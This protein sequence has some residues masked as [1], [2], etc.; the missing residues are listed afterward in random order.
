[1][2]DA[3]LQILVISLQVRTLLYDYLTD[4]EQGSVSGRNPISSINEI[5]RDGR[6]SR[7]RTKVRFGSHVSVWDTHILISFSL[8]SVLLTQT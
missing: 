5:L 8:F 3:L 6:F 2:N 7:D 4:E 1:L